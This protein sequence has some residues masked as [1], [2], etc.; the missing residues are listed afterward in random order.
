MANPLNKQVNTDFA[1]VMGW[2]LLALAVVF[3]VVQATAQSM[4][5]SAVG[6]EKQVVRQAQ[7]RAEAFERWRSNDAFAGFIADP[8]WESDEWASIVA[9]EES[10]NTAVWDE[11]F[12]EGESRA[13]AHWVP[14]NLISPDKHYPAAIEPMETQLPLTERSMR[15]PLLA[16]LKDGAEACRSGNVE[17]WLTGWDGPASAASVTDDP[18][19]TAVWVENAPAIIR[20]A[21]NHYC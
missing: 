8:V 17:T 15:P 7:E 21:A 18:G 10:Q 12:A 16:I 6:V 11:R 4:G 20:V 5:R 19:Y 1:A 14:T 13:K 3:V 2:F 9:A